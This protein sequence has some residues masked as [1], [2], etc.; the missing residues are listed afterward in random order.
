VAPST[1]GETYSRWLGFDSRRTITEPPSG[2]WYVPWAPWW[3]LTSPVPPCGIVVTASIEEAPSNSR[4][5]VS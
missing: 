1:T 4:K 3:Y 2:S 5:I